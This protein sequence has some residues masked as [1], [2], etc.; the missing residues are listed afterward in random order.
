MNSD[1]SSTGRGSDIAV[2]LT[3]TSP[4]G[5]FAAGTAAVKPSKALVRNG[6]DGPLVVAFAAVTP[7][8]NERNGL[9]ADA[10]KIAA[11][12]APGALPPGASAEVTLS[13]AAPAR[14]GCYQAELDLKCEGGTSIPTPLRVEVA[15]SALWG[16]VCLLFGLSLLGVVKLLTHQGDVE[17]L[18]RNAL[19][20]RAAV[21]ANWQRNPPPASRAETVAEIERNYDGALR[22]LAPLQGFSIVD[23]R[24]A[25]ASASL[26]DARRADAELRD[27]MTAPPGVMEVADLEREWTAFKSLLAGLAAPPTGAS[28]LQGLPA[29][30]QALVEGLQAHLVAARAQAI[31]SGLEPHVERIRLAMAAGEGPRAREMALAMRAWQRRA[32]DDLEKQQAVEMGFALLGANML[33]IE[34]RLRRLAGDESIPPEAR[35]KWIAS[36]DAA[37]AKLASGLTLENFKQ[38]NELVQDAETQSM[39][40]QKDVLLARVREA[41]QAASDEL[42]LDAVGAAFAKMGPPG[43]L[44]DADYAA[45]M[46]KVFEAWRASLGPFGDEESRKAI[47]TIADSG[48]DAAKRQDK[49]AIKLAFGA[50]KDE[51]QALTPK[52]VA[53]VAAR[54][55]APICGDW[56]DANLMQT[57]VAAEQVRLQSGRPEVE[58]WEKALDR[59]RLALQA[60]STSDPDCL[61]KA[62]EADNET[63]A[64][65]RATYQHVLED[66]AIPLDA[67]LDAAERSGDAAAVALIQRLAS[68]PRELK[69]VATTKEEDIVVGQPIH[70][71]FANLDPNWSGPGVDVVVDWGDGSE[72]L[73]TTAE[74]LLESER[75]EHPYQQIKT[76]TLKATASIGDRKVGESI[77]PLAVGPSPANFAQRLADIFLTS[78]FGLAL[79]IASVVYFWRFHAGTVV[80]GSESLHY[81]QAFALGLAAYAAV[82]DLPK[83]LGE[84]A[85]R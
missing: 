8:V 5:P 58:N 84:L 6:T 61:G 80:F 15:A 69:L 7:L 16:V 64:V 85:L 20:E 10:G 60:I 26:A 72:P 36:L 23:R 44:S 53:A 24:I 65:S 83:A 41:T 38:A 39:R 51:W 79:L 18:T 42:S 43:A 46:A 11:D 31:I 66:A 70:F 25:D 74:K 67:R 14:A 4:W 48:I 1:S 45:A 27:A 76:F 22:S 35:A 55:V 30:V 37:D 21:R 47:Q 29:H 17:E 12:V 13:G 71:A 56:R 63:L 59:A 3:A 34:T 81:V 2:K 49:P 54:V 57:T 50:L 19:L 68:G 40:D 75:P 28:P 32:A 78:Q 62:V 33:A 77:L 73:R 82:A 52:Y 9:A